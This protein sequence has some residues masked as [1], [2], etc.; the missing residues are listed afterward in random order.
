MIGRLGQAAV[1]ATLAAAL[2]GAPA[3]SRAY[4]YVGDVDDGT[5]DTPY[6]FNITD[7]LGFEGG[8]PAG[9]GWFFT[10][11]TIPPGETLN[12]GVNTTLTGTPTKTGSFT[13]DLQ[14]N[15]LPPYEVFT[16]QLTEVVGVPEP[17]TWAM[18]L[19]GFAGLGYA[20]YR[21]SRRSVALGA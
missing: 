17:S 4:D 14:N 1:R 8:L 2:I 16:A 6:S 5:L 10:G 7:L 11:G 3:V 19:I 13:F 20:G 18:M 15:Y 12:V 9:Q 21:A